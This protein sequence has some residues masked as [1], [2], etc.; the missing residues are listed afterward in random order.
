MRVSREEN[1]GHMILEISLIIW[2][3]NNLPSIV[4]IASFSALSPLLLV[5]PF[6]AI[7]FLVSPFLLRWRQHWLFPCSLAEY[8]R[9]R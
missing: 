3:E 1:K 7:N 4:P 5:F 6:P 2:K 8:D 9:N